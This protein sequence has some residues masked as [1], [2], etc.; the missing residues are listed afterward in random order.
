MSRLRHAVDQIVFARNYTRGLLDTIPESD[1]FR[2][3]AEGVTHVAWQVGHLAMAQYRLIIERLRGVRPED[4]Q[5]IP[6]AMLKA[7]GRGSVTDP[8]PAKY[9]PTAEIRSAFDR[10]HERVLAELADFP[11]ADLDSPI[12]TSHRFCKTKMDCVWWCSAHEMVH[13]G[14]IALLRRLFGQKP[15]W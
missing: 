2:M 3:P 12:L 7:F 9:P 13:G 6:A 5:L 1:W 11:D 15:I 10:V 8:D 4:E 14:Q